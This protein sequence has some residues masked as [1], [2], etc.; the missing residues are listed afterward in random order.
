MPIPTESLTQL[1]DKSNNFRQIIARL[2]FLFLKL[3]PASKHSADKRERRR[4]KIIKNYLSVVIVVLLFSTQNTYRT[5]LH[6][7]DSVIAVGTILLSLL[8]MA[9]SLATSA[10]TVSTFGLSI[11]AETTDNRHT[12][13]FLLLHNIVHNEITKSHNTS[14]RLVSISIASFQFSFIQTQKVN[15]CLRD[16]VFMKN[17]FI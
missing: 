16:I 12:N 8:T 9:A 7:S 2:N 17:V 3:S 13:T 15:F 14:I 4:K 1:T 6:L 11:F 5:E 10:L